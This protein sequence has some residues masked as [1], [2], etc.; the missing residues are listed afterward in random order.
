VAI[1]GVQEA[2]PQLLVTVIV[3]PVPDGDRFVNML[4]ICVADSLQLANEIV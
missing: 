3:L 2:A 1:D 4:F